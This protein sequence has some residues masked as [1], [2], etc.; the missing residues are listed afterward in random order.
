MEKKPWP[1]D[2]VMVVAKPEEEA[3]RTPMEGRHPCRCRDCG[4]LLVADT[5]AVRR[6]EGHPLRAGRPVKF[7][8][9]GCARGYAMPGPARVARTDKPAARRRPGD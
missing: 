1:A 8:C 3:A 6:A 7:F 9:H 5:F 4:A 2:A